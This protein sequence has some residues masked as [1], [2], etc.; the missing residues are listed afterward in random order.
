MEIR[1]KKCNICGE[2]KKLTEFYHNF[3]RCKSCHIKIT[4]RDTKLRHLIDEDTKNKHITCCRK[5]TSNRSIET[6]E[7]ERKRQ[8]FRNAL[9]RAK[10][11]N[12][13]LPNE[14]FGEIYIFYMQCPIGFVVDH[15][16]PFKGKG[17]VVNGLHTLANLQYLTLKE[18]NLKRCQVFQ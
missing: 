5:R 10:R 15:I 8:A 9:I 16:I 18:N 7:L 3:G 4:T 2:Y 14:L 6:V 12:A 13:F 11:L 1:I 17:N